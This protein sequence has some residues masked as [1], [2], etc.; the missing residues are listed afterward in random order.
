M[1]QQEMFGSAKWLTRAGCQ[2]TDIL[3]LRGHFAANGVKK[4]TLRVLGLGFFHCYINGVRVGE[5]L[6]LPLNSEY[7]PRADFPVGEQLSDFRTYVPEYDVTSH[8]RD[9]ENVIAIHFGGG[10]YTFEQNIKKQKKKYGDPKVIWRLFGESAEGGFEL[11]SSLQDKIAP[12]F[13]TGYRFDRFETQDYTKA[14]PAF[15]AA[16]F[17]DAAWSTA[18]E[19]PPPDTQYGFSDCPADSVGEV[20]APKLL[21]RRGESAL[22]DS[23]KNISGTPVLRLLGKEGQTVRVSLS[24]DVT[25]EGELDPKFSHKQEFTCVCDGTVREARA[26]FTWF[27]FRYFLV[28][29]DA[30]PVAV[31]FIHT[32]VARTSHFHCDNEDLNW[33]HD[34]FLTTQLS[35]MHAGIPSDCPHIERRGY[36]GDG[37]LAGL[38]AMK[39]LDTEAFYRKWMQDIADSQDKLT[40]H[41]QNT[42]PYT[43]SGGGLGGWG[44][45]IVEIPWQYY[46]HFGNAAPLEK[47]YPNMLRYFDYME[48]HSERDLVTSDKAGEWCLGD[49]CCPTS[50][51][52]PAPLVNTY[53]YI[54]SMTRVIEIARIIGKES[55][56]VRFEARIAECKEALRSAYCNTWD[57][58]FLGAVQ[59]AN[60]FAVDLGIG[61]ERTWNNLVA[62]YEKLGELDTGIFAT[63]LL[64]RLLLESGEGELAMRLLCSEGVHSFTEM[65]RRGATTIREHWPESYRDRSHSHPMFGAVVSHLYTYL[66]GIRQKPG[67]VA[68]KELVIAPVAV[69]G[70][71]VLE[72]Y[73]DLP[74][75]R[76]AVSYVKKDGALDL[77]VE[78]PEGACAALCF[79][80]NETPLSEGKTVLHLAIGEA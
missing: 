48:L 12:S 45:G 30:E 54:K 73:M 56:I 68:Y 46:L 75:G 74:C 40:G 33:L 41:V 69:E 37:H 24:E 60:A 70:I 34:A 8:L 57:G 38:A 53:F 42:A 20:L 17:D 44:S 55:D 32:K 39:M 6:F 16:D 59:G 51:V 35:N 47:Y 77:T 1:T 26:L 62:Y 18:D 72:G 22:Y 50:V 80:G 13:V 3:V 61:D 31:D 78:L 5:D 9:G 21:W 19:A 10:W 15:L 11:T 65:R 27:G 64:I 4:A 67:S 66:L 14:S 2:N 28:E 49:W 76:V 25:A 79:G 23:G 29:G 43:H 52:L 36:T 58:N 7:E 63:E 71:N